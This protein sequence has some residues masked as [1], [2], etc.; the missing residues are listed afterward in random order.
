MSWDVMESQH[1]ER[2][3]LMCSRFILIHQLSY[4]ATCAEL[5][6]VPFQNWKFPIM[7]KLPE[8]EGDANE[9]AG[10]CNVFN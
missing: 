2:Y 4:L 9:G 8:S 5:T 1:T 3:S 7:A 10:H 6:Q